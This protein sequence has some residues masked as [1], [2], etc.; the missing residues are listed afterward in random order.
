MTEFTSDIKTVPYSQEKVFATLSDLNNLEKFRAQI[1]ADKISDFEFD[2]DY[3]S[4]TV[5]PVGKIG[6]RVVERE[7]SKTIKFAGEK[8]PVNLNMWIQLKEAAPNDTRMK[9]TVRAELNPFIKGMVSKPL[10]E[11]VNKIADVLA[12]IPYGEAL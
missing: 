4:F 5:N 6:F 10:Q 12:A 3:C 9:L 2:S 8:L 1:P 7:P 11:G